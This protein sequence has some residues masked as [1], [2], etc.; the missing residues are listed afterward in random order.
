MARADLGALWT[1]TS[2]PETGD[3]R[4]PVASAAA[5]CDC[6][7]EASDVVRMDG[8]GFL[9]GDAAL[10]GAGGARGPASPTG[11]GELTDG[12]GIVGTADIS[13]SGLDLAATAPRGGRGPAATTGCGAAEATTARRAGSGA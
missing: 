5:Y 4:V 1:A 7:S 8:T 3:F 9:S 10:G 13:V 11:G 2:L 6:L 12:G